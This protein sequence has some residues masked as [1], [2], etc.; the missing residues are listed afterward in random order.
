MKRVVRRIIWQVSA[1][2]AAL[3]M[4]GAVR[5]QVE[6]ALF[7]SAMPPSDG[8]AVVK[9]QEVAEQVVVLR[10]GEILCG[11]VTLR[12]ERYVIARAMG[13]T[14]IPVSN[15]MLV[16]SSLEAAYQVRRER[17]FHARAEDHLVLAEWCLRHEIF[18]H[19]HR[20][21]ADARALDARNEKLPMLERRL[22]LASERA[23]KGM[24]TKPAVVAAGA[25]RPAEETASGVELAQ[26]VAPAADDAISKLPPGAVERFTRRVQP[27]LVNSCTTAG[28]HDA[29]GK[30]QFQLDRALLH[31]LSNRRTTMS[32]LSATLA[33]VD[34][35][36]PQQSPLLTVP[37]E[38]HGGMESPVF[39]PRQEAAYRHL[40][41]WVALVTA[42]TA[43]A[44]VMPSTPPQSPA[45]LTTPK[46]QLAAAKR[47][48]RPARHQ[49]A[50]SQSASDGEAG[51]AEA[52]SD[53]EIESA[54]VPPL[55][56]RYG[57][58]LKRW[59]PRDEFDPEIFNR[60]NSRPAEAAGD[61]STKDSP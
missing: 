6:Q 4:T 32:N 39:G 54:R 43:K 61:R 20:E 23:E 35:K 28:C 44:P 47:E 3:A 60:Q 53:E 11:R 52:L 26:F 31:G 41:E 50:A 57:T 15:V 29:G 9:P 58:S 16:A 8:D 7:E 49:V 33:L 5:A 25:V 56:P 48:V 17:I 12:N 2:A 34:R 10:D 40:Y 19:A 24:R 45:S 46:P 13:E 18:A 38:T 21:L 30:A 37:R 27:V 1:V 42:K 59:E 14:F 36:N 55:P 51:D 22:Q